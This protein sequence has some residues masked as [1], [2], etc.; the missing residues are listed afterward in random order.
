MKNFTIDKYSMY[1]FFQLDFIK[2]N[3]PLLKIF[4]KYISKIYKF[5]II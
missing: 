5:P 4:F 3:I 1:Y 2:C